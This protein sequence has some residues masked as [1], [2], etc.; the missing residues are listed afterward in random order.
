MRVIKNK[1]IRKENLF[2]NHKFILHLL[3]RKKKVW[4]EQGFTM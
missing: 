3:E 2:P 1:T 4:N